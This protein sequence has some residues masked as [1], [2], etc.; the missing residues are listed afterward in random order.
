MVGGWRSA[1]RMKGVRNVMTVSGRNNSVK[2]KGIPGE[3]AWKI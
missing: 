1:G 2:R 3:L